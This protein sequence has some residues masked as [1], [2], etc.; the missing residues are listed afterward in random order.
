MEIKVRVL[1][2]TISCSRGLGVHRSTPPTRCESCTKSSIR[3]DRHPYRRSPD[4]P[5]AP[6]TQ[7]SL[8]VRS[9]Q[10]AAVLP[11]LLL[12][13]LA[14]PM[15]ARRVLWLEVPLSLR[16]QEPAFQTRGSLRHIAQRRPEDR[17]SVGDR[18]EY[19]S[20]LEVRATK[21]SAAALD[22]VVLL[23]HALAS[24][25]DHRCGPHTQAKRG[26][27]AQSLPLPHHQRRSGGTLFTRASNQSFCSRIPQPRTLQNHHLL[28]PRRIGASSANQL[29]TRKR[30][31]V[32]TKVR[33]RRA[34]G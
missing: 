4:L 28:P 11:T 29:T 1:R 34:K 26:R 22:Q 20:L 25:A 30:H 32:F 23:G 3:R 6:S 31:K 13:H 12:A 18:G 8:G 19:A 9:L 24:G 33:T 27:S 10:Y 7:S 16:R 17:S 15:S 14:A 5:S 2:T 21:L